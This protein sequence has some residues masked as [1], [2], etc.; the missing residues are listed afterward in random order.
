MATHSSV[1]YFLFNPHRALPLRGDKILPLT[2]VRQMEG[3]LES[4]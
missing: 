1:G 3:V 4:V 2:D